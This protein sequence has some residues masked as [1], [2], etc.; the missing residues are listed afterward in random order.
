MS[1]TCLCPDSPLRSL[2]SQH[3]GLAQA[4]SEITAFTLDPGVCEILRVPF[5]SEVSISQSCEA[6][7]VPALLFSR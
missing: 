4:L 1:D 6:S 2:Q 5:E 3:V 7:A